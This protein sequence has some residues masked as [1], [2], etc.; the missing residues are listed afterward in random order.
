M[1]IVKL[2]EEKHIIGAR[3]EK[4]IYGSKKHLVLKIIQTIHGSCL[5]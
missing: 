3:L 1:K 2:L 4:L 5:N